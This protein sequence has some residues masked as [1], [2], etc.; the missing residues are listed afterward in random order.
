MKAK[1]INEIR[2]AYIV[3]GAQAE[4]QNAMDIAEWEREKIVDSATAQEL[5][6]YNRILSKKF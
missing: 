6:S 3:L 1:L 5:K 4:C 2:R